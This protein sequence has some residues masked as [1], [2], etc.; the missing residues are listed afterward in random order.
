MNYLVGQGDQ[1]SRIT[2][3][4]YSEERPICTEKTENR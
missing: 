2:V 1:A 4:S 3:V